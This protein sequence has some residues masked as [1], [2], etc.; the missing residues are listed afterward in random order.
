VVWVVVAALGVVAALAGVFWPDV[1]GMVL[2]G[3][4]PGAVV[5]VVVLGGQWM[6]HKRYRSRVV[7]MPGF[8]RVKPGSS[9]TRSTGSNRPMARSGEPST[10]EVPP[11]RAE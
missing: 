5:V 6:L 10:T 8:A 7:F 2:Y 3:C 9:L 1:V 11:S 4:E